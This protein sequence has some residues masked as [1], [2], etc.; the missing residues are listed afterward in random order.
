MVSIINKPKQ[1]SNKILFLH[2]NF[3]IGNE[4]S[5]DEVI[6]KLTTK[7]ND[8]IE[9]IH[10]HCLDLFDLDILYLTRNVYVVKLIEHPTIGVKSYGYVSLKDLLLYN[11]LHTFKEIRKE[12]NVYK[13]LI[14]GSFSF[15]SYL[16]TDEEDKTLEFINNHYNLINKKDE[17]LSDELSEEWCSVDHIISNALSGK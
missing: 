4:I 8:Q 13:M 9:T 3:T 5:R 7:R 12:H 15:K 16:N 10:S 14:A 2:T 6:E 1:V 11:N 17:V